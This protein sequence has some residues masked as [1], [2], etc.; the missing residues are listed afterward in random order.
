MSVITQPC[1][2]FK[3]PSV[4]IKKTVKMAQTRIEYH[5]VLLK[6]VLPFLKKPS[7]MQFYGIILKL[8]RI[9]P[10]CLTTPKFAVI[11]ISS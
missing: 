10:A 4:M 1:V 6:E 11:I 8:K 2:S 5:V 3:D 9:T 7:Q